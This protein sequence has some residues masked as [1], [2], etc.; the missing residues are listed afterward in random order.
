MQTPLIKV[1][2]KILTYINLT[3]NKQMGGSVQEKRNIVQ[4]ETMVH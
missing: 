4:K 1:K 3:D 2:I